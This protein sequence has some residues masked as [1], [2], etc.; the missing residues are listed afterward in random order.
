MG[1]EDREPTGLECLT[2]AR[3]ALA[4]EGRRHELD[5]LGWRQTLQKLTALDWRA[6]HV[7]AAWFEHDYGLALTALVPRAAK[8]HADSVILAAVLGGEPRIAE[9]P[10]LSTTYRRDEGPLR[11]G[12]E[13]WLP[14]GEGEDLYPVRASGE[15]LGVSMSGEHDGVSL[16]AEPFRW[17]SRDRAG[18]GVY[19]RG[20]R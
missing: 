17:Y 13:L 16:E 8:N 1:A 11:A 20:H 6:V 4:L 9:D 12:I 14:G 19:L 10:R 15:A 7:L 18:A 2:E 5:C 3:G